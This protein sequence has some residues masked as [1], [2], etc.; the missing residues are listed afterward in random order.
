M[1]IFE[2]GGMCKMT[3]VEWN[4]SVISPDFSPENQLCHTSPARSKMQQINA[5]GSKN[6][7]MNRTRFSIHSTKEKGN[8]AQLFCLLAK[9]NTHN[10]GTNNQEF[11]IV[12]CKYLPCIMA[13]GKSFSPFS[14]KIR[15]WIQMLLKLVGKCQICTIWEGGLLIQ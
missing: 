1:Q 9:Y 6:L 15:I 4:P 14:S 8:P 7:K 13:N 2:E 11:S 10:K 12:T 5:S 3:K